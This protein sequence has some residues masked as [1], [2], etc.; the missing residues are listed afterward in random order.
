MWTESTVGRDCENDNNK[1]TMSAY[2]I[3]CYMY[4]VTIIILT[5]ALCNRY[6]PFTPYR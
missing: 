2:Y 3:V 6:S 4:S 5:K 1:H